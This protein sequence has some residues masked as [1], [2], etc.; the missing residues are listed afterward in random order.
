MESVSLLGSLHRDSHKGKE[1][2][3]MTTFSWVSACTDLPI[4]AKTVCG[5]YEGYSR[6]KTVQSESLVTFHKDLQILIWLH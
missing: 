3:E 4:P 1:T 2:S 6:F 5:S